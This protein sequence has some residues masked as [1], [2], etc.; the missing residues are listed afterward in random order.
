[1]TALSENQLNFFRNLIVQLEG[2]LGFPEFHSIHYSN[3]E[4]ERN[5]VTFNIF[6][7]RWDILMFE[8]ELVT[9]EIFRNAFSG[10]YPKHVSS[11]RLKADYSS[12]AN[13]IYIFYFG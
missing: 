6:G 10:K 11:K 8:E 2:G 9:I 3:S 5:G 4:G 1:M 12:I 7:D 13:S